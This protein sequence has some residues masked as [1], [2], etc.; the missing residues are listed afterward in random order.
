MRQEYPFPERCK[1]LQD[2][3]DLIYEGIATQLLGIESFPT[4]KDGKDL[5]Y[6]GIATTRMIRQRAFGGRID[7]KDLIYEGIATVSTLLPNHVDI[8]LVGTE[9]T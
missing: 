8:L 5:I 1:P 6:E 9:K 4:S 7:G 3:K 2:G